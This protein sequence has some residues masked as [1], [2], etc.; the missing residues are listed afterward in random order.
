MN[1]LHNTMNM[2]SVKNFKCRLNGSDMQFPTNFVCDEL[3]N[4]L[5]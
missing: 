2:N 4:R 1:N 5:N 3:K